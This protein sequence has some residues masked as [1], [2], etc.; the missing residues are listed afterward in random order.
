MVSTA[1]AVSSSR[2]SSAKLLHMKGVV[3]VVVDDEVV[4]LELLLVVPG[5]TMGISPDQQ[6]K[7]WT[8]WDLYN[9]NI[10]GYRMGKDGIYSEYTQGYTV[11]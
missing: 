10:M 3:V 11:E 9:G 8:Q 5:V 1:I 7:C 2:S 6:E 4:V